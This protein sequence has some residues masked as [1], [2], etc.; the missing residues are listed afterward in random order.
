MENTAV[1][2]KRAD[3]C[4]STQNDIANDGGAASTGPKHSRTSAV[5]DLQRKKAGANQIGRA[6]KFDAHLMPCTFRCRMSCV[7]FPQKKK[8]KDK[9]KAKTWKSAF[10]RGRAKVT[11]CEWTVDQHELPT[12][13]RIRAALQNAQHCESKHKQTRCLKWCEQCADCCVSSCAENNKHTTQA[14]VAHV[15]DA[16]NVLVVTTPRPNDARLVERSHHT[17][18]RF[19][20]RR[21]IPW[22][23]IRTDVLRTSTKHPS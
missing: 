20:S 5:N 13:G 16:R 3:H 8:T 19:A 11:L 10:P 7:F 21:A 1:E 2:N 12:R 15:F 17:M 18:R 23:L 6:T 22:T 9:T 14:L 4:F